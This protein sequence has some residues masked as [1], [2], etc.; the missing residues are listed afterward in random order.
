MKVVALVGEGN[1][2]KSHT[3][4]V[5]YNFLLKDGYCQIP[6]HFR[7]LGNPIYEDFIDILEKDEIKI[8][9]AGMGDYITGEG[10]S[11]KNLLAELYIKECDVAICACRNNPKMLM[12]VQSYTPHS[13]VIKT[14]SKGNENHRIV[15]VADAL[16]IIA[17]I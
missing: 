1:T 2:G 7:I 6:E 4:N 15:N 9:F 5:V 13:I 17:L 3:I 14:L 8:G 12:A 16:K 11:I 10:R